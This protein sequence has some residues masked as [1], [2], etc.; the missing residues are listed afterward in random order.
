MTNTLDY[1]NLH[2][3]HAGHKVRLEG[4]H[5]LMLVTGA[6]HQMSTIQWTHDCQGVGVLLGLRGPELFKGL[7]SDLYACLS[8]PWPVGG[9]LADRAWFWLMA[10]AVANYAV[11]AMGWRWL[12]QLMPNPSSQWVTTRLEWIDVYHQASQSVRTGDLPSTQHQPATFYVQ[13]LNRLAAITAR[14][15]LGQW[16]NRWYTRM[17]EV[18]KAATT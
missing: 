15:L 2:L 8:L 7:N 1:Y 17:E 16:Y 5:G 13:D 3:A 14:R 10:D 9:L 12:V 4:D 11:I 18:A 6:R